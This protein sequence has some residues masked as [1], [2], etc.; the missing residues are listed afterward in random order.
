M[1]RADLARGGIDDVDG[2]PRIIDKEALARGVHL[3]E[4]G[5]E[6]GGPRVIPAAKLRVLVALGR[7]L[8]VLVPEE[9]ERDALAT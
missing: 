3:P 6:V 2:L 9:L 8:L 4:D 1:R 5:I 7:A